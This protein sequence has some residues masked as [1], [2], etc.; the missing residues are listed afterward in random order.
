ME[1]TLTL[2]PGDRYRPANLGVADPGAAVALYVQP[3]SG[4]TVLAI[5]GAAA[6]MRRLGR[7]LYDAGAAAEKGP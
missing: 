4:A 3:A 6:E 7:A 1:L 2:E 5:I